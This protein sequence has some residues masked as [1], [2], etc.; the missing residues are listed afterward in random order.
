MGLIF[1]LSFALWI[2]GCAEKDRPVAT[3]GE[4]EISAEQLRGFIQRLSTG[5]KSQSSG[6]VFIRSIRETQKIPGAGHAQK[7]ISQNL[8]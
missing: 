7:E 6:Q 3:I 4:Q 2:S 5:L 8:L 1:I